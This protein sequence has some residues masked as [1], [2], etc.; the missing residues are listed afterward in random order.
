MLHQEAKNWPDKRMGF[1][2]SRHRE[3]PKADA[4]TILSQNSFYDSSVTFG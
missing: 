4:S 1:Y 3:A 2:L